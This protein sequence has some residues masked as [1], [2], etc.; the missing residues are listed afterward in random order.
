M[1]FYDI[2]RTV[3]IV[4]IFAQLNF[5]YKFALIAIHMTRWRREGR[6]GGGGGGKMHKRSRLWNS[7]IEKMKT[8]TRRPS[9]T[10]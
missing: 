3:V 5:V 2:T 8:Q 9:A 4:V 7:T 6:E 10:Y 1:T